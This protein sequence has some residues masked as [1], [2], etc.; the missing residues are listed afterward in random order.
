MEQQMPSTEHYALINELT[1]QALG[2]YERQSLA[3]FI[4]NQTSRLFHYEKATVWDMELY[5]PT[6]LAV[7]GQEPTENPL[8][9]S[10]E[11]EKV[12]HGIHDKETIQIVANIASKSLLWVPVQI[13][14]RTTLGIL[15]ERP[16]ERV[17]SEDEIK[18]ITILA[19]GYGYAWKGAFPNW[20]LSIFQRIRWI[21]IALS[22]VILLSIIPVSSRIHAP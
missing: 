4:V 20:S 8:E 22:C 6:L 13:D 5:N 11:T 16:S 9:V 3:S 15:F 10:K 12:I 7:S 18:N 2:C 17:W 21:V 1:L 19:Q 14:E